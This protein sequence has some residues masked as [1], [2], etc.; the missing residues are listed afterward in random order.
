MCKEQIKTAKCVI[1]WSEI[2][3]TEVLLPC[4]VREQRTTPA[5]GLGASS[6]GEEAFELDREGLEN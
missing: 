6:T 5:S 2:H 1:R 4:R 3:Y